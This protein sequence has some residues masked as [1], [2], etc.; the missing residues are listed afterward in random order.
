MLKTLRSTLRFRRFRL[1]STARRL[2]RCANVD[3]LRLMAKRRLPGG[4]FDYID[5]AA[6]DETTLRRSIEGFG[7][8]EFVPRVLRDVS[9]IDTSTTLLGKTIAFPFVLAPTGFTRMADSQGELAVARAAER[10]ALP[11]TLSTMGTRSIEEVAEVS[12][13]A[14]WF[15]VYVWRDRGLVREMIERSAEAG[16]QA[17]CITVDLATL[18]RRERDVRRGFTMPPKIGPDT[19]VDAIRRP[20]WTRDFLRGGPI[21]FASTATRRSAGDDIGDGTDAVS[22]ARFTAEQLDP[23]LNWDDLA[24]FREIWDGPIVIKGIQCVED[25]KIAADLGVEAIALSNHGGRQLE[26]SPAP[27]SLLPRVADALGGQ[28]ELIVDGGIRRGGD[29]IKALAL[30][31]TS[32]MGGRA[33]L[34]GLGAAGERG[35]DTAL[36]FLR[37]ELERSMILSGLTRIAEIGPHTV[38][39][40]R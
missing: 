9:S 23:S 19:V 28:V 31:A 12:E 40:V 24:W 14:K 29:I 26:G 20:G 6:E 32:T 13:G 21:R 3:D 27:I 17:I 36:A 18:G 30:G 35:V 4:V 15:Q 2:E 8:F 5:G 1:S 38:E 33:Y 25:A 11:Y 22:L 37:S 39:K 16:Y 34:Y 7:D 10:A